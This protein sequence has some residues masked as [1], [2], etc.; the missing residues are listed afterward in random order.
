MIIR[1]RETFVRLFETS[2]VLLGSTAVVGCG[3]NDPSDEDTSEV[4]AGGEASTSGSTG[5]L[6][7]SPMMGSTTSSGSSDQGSGTTSDTTDTTDTTSTTTEEMSTSSSTTGASV[8]ESSSTTDEDGIDPCEYYTETL[9][10]CFGVDPR[11]TFAE[12]SFTLE[13]FEDV[14]EECG[15]RAAE[16]FTC[17]STQECRALAGEPVVC[18]E[19]VMAMA[20]SCG[21]E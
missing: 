14:S 13:M 5:G 10:D 8:S 16:L 4:S 15:D 11:E 7:S 2:M 3:T 6:E 21:L 17:I 20:R 9:V 18:E 1:K 19:E 12:C